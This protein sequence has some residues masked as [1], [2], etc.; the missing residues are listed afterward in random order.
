LKD[1]PGD[2]IRGDDTTY[3]ELLVE[4]LFGAHPGSLAFTA[5]SAI[6]TSSAL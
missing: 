2:T 3:E 1:A 6:L 5:H 4:E